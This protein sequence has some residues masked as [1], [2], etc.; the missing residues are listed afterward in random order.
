MK[1]MKEQSKQWT[2][3]GESAE[4][5]SKT[6]PSAGKV[7]ASVFW[8]VREMIFIEVLQKGEIIN[9]EF[10]AAFEWCN[11]EEAAAFGGKGVVLY[12]ASVHTSVIALAE[13]KNE[14]LD[15]LMHPIRLL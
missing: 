5:K 7:M 14:K 1:M 4:K 2:E 6:I 10:I 8:D 13:I 12:N 9:G 11:Q 3:R 15:L